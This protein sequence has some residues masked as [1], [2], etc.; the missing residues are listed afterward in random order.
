MKMC[1]R[2]N[3]VRYCVRRHTI[4]C[5]TVHVTSKSQ[6][7]DWTSHKR[8]GSAPQF[9]DIGSWIQ[10]HEWVIQWA[11]METLQ[12][13]TN[14]KKILKQCLVINVL[15]V[16]PGPYP[17][18]FAIFNAH[19]S[20]MTEE[21]F[22][23]ECDRIAWLKI[24]KSGGMGRALVVQYEGWEVLKGIANGTLLASSR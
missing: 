24:Q 10:A 13:H 17:S 21:F 5:L 15:G 11:A 8:G 4:E 7:R 6:K 3:F 1:A 18:P 22:S 16:V 19:V 14:S 20:D 9:I 23:P 2:C 12:V